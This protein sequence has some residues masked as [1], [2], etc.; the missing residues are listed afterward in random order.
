MELVSATHSTHKVTLTR[1]VGNCRAS[2]RACK[3]SPVLPRIRTTPDVRGIR[4]RARLLL[5]YSCPAYTTINFPTALLWK[6][7][8]SLSLSVCLSSSLPLPLTPLSPSSGCFSVFLSLVTT[9]ARY[10][11]ELY[12]RPLIHLY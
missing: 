1:H 6:S 2:L 5:G 3:E 10:H 8:C 4:N 7:F 11:R 12:A 9:S